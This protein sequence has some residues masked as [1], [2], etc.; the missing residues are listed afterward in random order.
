[1][2]TLYCFISHA[3]HFEICFPILAAVHKRGNAKVFPIVN[4]RLKKTDRELLTAFHKVGISPVFRSR[5]NIELLSFI[6]MK[7]ADAI[8]SYGDPL[9]M[10]KKIRMR[11]KYLVA[12]RTPSIF[13]Q[14]GL[15]QEGINLDWIHLGPNWYSSRILWWEDYL[16]DKAPFLTKDVG[17]RIRKV[18]F[19]KKN[20]MDTKQFPKELMGYINSFRQRLLVCTT[21][22]GQKHRFDDANLN[23]TYNMFDQFCM[24]NPDVLLLMRPHRGKQD[25][26]GKEFDDI[27][28]AKH[29][30]VI[31]MDR[32]AGDFAYT[33]IHD[34]LA[35]TDLVLGHASS[36]VL[37][38]MYA[39]LPTAVLH[40]DW[41]SFEYLDQVTNLASLE[42]FCSQQ[43]CVDILHN[44]TR[45]HFGEL[46]DNLD[47]A[48]IHIEEVMGVQSSMR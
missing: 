12:S 44:E 10:P 25:Q 7:R 18:G 35:I 15:I 17:S 46:D 28:A 40:N 4:R 1:M 47:R 19:L 48:A 22:P 9:A 29:Q 14:H 6:S 30:N 36:A 42:K 8:L 11:D 26:R 13:T 39:D 31:V 5:A 16:P 24:R 3:P 41:S 43:G 34:C 23:E 33:N 45:R 32:Y 2:K 27:L 38:S 37:D 20:Y 21:M